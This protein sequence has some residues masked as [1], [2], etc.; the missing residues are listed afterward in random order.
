[1]KTCKIDGTKVVFDIDGRTQHFTIDAGSE[2]VYFAMHHF[3]HE[4]IVDS[5]GSNE[6][7]AKLLKYL[8]GYKP[9]LIESK[10]QHLCPACQRPL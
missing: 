1:M 8:P 10:E 5:F 3:T 7:T 2:I 4:E 9:N 6:V